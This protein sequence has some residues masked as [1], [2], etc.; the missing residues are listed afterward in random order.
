M[1]TSILAFIVAA[2]LGG[3][4]LEALPM[5]QA[6]A[7]TGQLAFVK[8]SREVREVCVIEADGTN[9]H[10]SGSTVS[11]PHYQPVWSPDGDFILYQQPYVAGEPSSYLLDVESGVTTAIALPLFDGRVVQWSPD[12]TQF[13]LV[14]ILNEGEDVEIYTLQTD[15]SDLRPL[16]DNDNPDNV[17][18]WSPDGTQ[19]AYIAYLDNRTLMVMQ[20]DGSNQQPISGELVLSLE[21]P[22]AWSPDNS[23]IAF[24]VNGDVIGNYETS[25]IYVVNADGTAL[26][27]LTDTGGVNLDPRW[28]PDGSQIVFW[29][30][31]LGAFDDTS[32]PG[33]RSEVFI[34][35]ADGS[36]LVNLTQN[37]GLDHSAEWSPDGEWIAFSSTRTLEGVE[38]RPGLFIMRP[39]GTDVRMVTNEPPFAEGGRE[40]NNPVWRP[41]AR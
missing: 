25:E 22:L 39:D 1:R 7:P 34:I 4:P 5:T 32:K 6:Q 30:Y 31:E 19:I 16:T 14:G 24:V 17:P 27:Q 20:A 9:L 10:C 23:Q 29:G 35:N 40:A 12:G 13:L 37:F 26:R 8:P 18:V 28:S 41:L 15:G 21:S 11:Y 2:L 38:P 36:D 33:L 3:I